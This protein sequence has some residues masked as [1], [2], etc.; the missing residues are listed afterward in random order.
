MPVF[1]KSKTVFIVLLLLREQKLPL[2]DLP[3][4]LSSGIYIRKAE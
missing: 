2:S 3:D 4:Q 1:G